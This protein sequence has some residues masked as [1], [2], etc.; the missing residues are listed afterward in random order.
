MAENKQ[1]RPRSITRGLRKRA[2]WL[3]RKNRKTTL[4]DLQLSI[5][6]GNEKDPVNNLRK[7]LNA[8]VDS[9]IVKRERIDDGK[10]TSNGSYLYILVND[11][12]PKPPLVRSDKQRVYDPNTGQDHPIKASEIVKEVVND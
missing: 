1:I 11:L 2:W 9:G 8:L 5:C 10:L 4:I 7:W 6:E 3:L 12:G